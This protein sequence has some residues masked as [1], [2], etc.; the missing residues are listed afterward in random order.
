ME[1]GTNLNDAAHHAEKL[2]ELLE[3]ARTAIRD[4][5]GY[6]LKDDKD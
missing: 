5:E 6:R 2:G 4:Q 3:A 1:A